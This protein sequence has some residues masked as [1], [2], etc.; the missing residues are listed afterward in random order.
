MLLDLAKALSFFL[1]ILSLYPVLTS[2]FFV[3]GAE[4]RERLA[5][6]LVHVGFAACIACASGL[7]FAAEPHGAG[8]RPRALVSTLPV[9]VFLWAMAG[10]GVLFILSWYLE[11]FYV[12]LM[13]HGCCRP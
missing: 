3:P 1:S 13:K 12:P 10:I 4:W 2:A 11:D 7:F 9:R 5:L 6:A 8:H